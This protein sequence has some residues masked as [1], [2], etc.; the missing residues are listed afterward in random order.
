MPPLRVYMPSVVPVDITGMTGTPGQ[1]LAASGSMRDRT[2]GAG[3]DAGLAIGGSST[4]T[5]T[6][7]PASFRITVSTSAPGTPGTIRQLITALARCG[8]A[9][10]AWP[11]STLVATHVVLSCAL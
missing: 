10:F 6:L 7:S 1:Y 4:L 8:R 5:R 3:A 9:L 2:A 11:A